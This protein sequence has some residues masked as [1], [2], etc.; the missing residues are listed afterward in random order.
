MFGINKEVDL[1]IGIYKKDKNQKEFLSQSLEK[2]FEKAL[3]KAK[4]I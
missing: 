2:D 1:V 3:K 4:I